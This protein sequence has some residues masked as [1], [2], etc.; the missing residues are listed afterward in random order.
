MDLANEPTTMTRPVLAVHRLLRLGRIVR[1]LPGPLLTS[2][3]VAACSGQ[4]VAQPPPPP[5][6]WR[7]FEH[8]QVDAGS[9]G[10]TAKESAL[11]QEYANAVASPGLALLGHLMDD[12]ARFA[13]PGMQDAHGR[14]AVVRAHEALFGAFDPRRFALT[15]VWR[16]ASEQSLEW[17]MG[18]VQV[19]DWMTVKATQKPVTIHGITLLSTKDD[20]TITDVRVYFDVATVKAQLGAGP[21]E[22]ADLPAPVMPPPGT[23]PQIVEQG[24]QDQDNVAVV[25]TALDALENTNENA[26]VEQM[27]DDGEIHTLERAQPLR[28]KEDR[29]A[30]FKALHKSIAQLDTTVTNGWSAGAYAIVEY[31]I[32]GEQIAPIAWVPVQRDQVVRLHVA[33]VDEIHDGKITRIWRFDNPSELSAPGP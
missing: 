21:R 15:R 20:G 11:A 23:A 22:L 31:G 29:R 24:A 32:T 18:G 8:A 12:D 6:N 10:P 4:N 2:V 27:T 13:F 5:V 9:T 7:S 17:T 25:R 28:G 16:S 14:D 1:G 33:D 30:Y 19:H 3:L 26:Y